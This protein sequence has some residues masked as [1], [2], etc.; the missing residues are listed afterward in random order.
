MR[1]ALI[2]VCFLSC[3]FLSCTTEDFSESQSTG[4]SN[5]LVE[6]GLPILEDRRKP[7]MLERLTSSSNAV[8]A[9]IYKIFDEQQDTHWETR[10]GNGPLESIDITFMGEGEVIGKLLLSPLIGDEY[11][12]IQE[13]NIYVD[14]HLK[15]FGTLS[16]T[17]AVDTLVK[18]L[19]IEFR[20]VGELNRSHFQFQ[21]ERVTLATFPPDQSI[22]LSY[23]SLYDTLGKEFKLIPP[24]RVNGRIA[25]SSNLNPL[26]LYHAGH[27]FDFKDHFAWVEGADGSGTGDSILFQ[28]D[29]TVCINKV[30]LHSGF[31]TTLDQFDANA[32]I[33]TLS[34]NPLEDTTQVFFQLPDAMVSNTILLPAKNAQSWV[35]K[36]IDIYPGK[37]TRDLAISEL[38]FFDCEGSPFILES[39]LGKQFQRELNTVVEGA[40]LESILG[41]YYQN[42]IE[43]DG[44]IRNQSIVL[45]PD[46]HF[47]VFI[48][49]FDRIKK[50]TVSKWGDGFW[51]ADEV[52]E[53][54]IK[55][56]LWGRWYRE[57]PRLETLISNVFEEDLLV[58]TST[59]EGANV[60][61]TFYLN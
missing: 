30:Q 9:D 44:V 43:N 55:L 53:E 1:K 10:P 2:S 4:I 20:Q 58:T 26:I 47:R 40:F 15:T 21:D 6:N 50:I 5:E 46:G 59:L 32:K 61:G 8:G 49:N 45:Y 14:H 54:S 29:T 7:L 28:F 3:C 60:L 48:Q 13:V 57:T 38:L 19:S 11:A 12:S 35:L 33:K 52:G 34:F 31:Q 24:K 36:I 56:K 27:L 39:G 51:S 22:G 16:D 37:V 25:S 42:E 18:H 23:L 17:I 41:R